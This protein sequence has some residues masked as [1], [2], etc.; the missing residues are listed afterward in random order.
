[1]GILI[2]GTLRKKMM[3]YI[4]IFKFISICLENIFALLKVIIP[5]LLITKLYIDVLT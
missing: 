5:F 3:F 4:L 2:I 1:M